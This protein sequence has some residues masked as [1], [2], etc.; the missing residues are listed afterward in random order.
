MTFNGEPGA[1]GRRHGPR[2]N[3]V[4]DAH[5]QL[6]DPHAERR[7]T[8]LRRLPGAARIAG[9]LRPF[10]ATA[11]NAF[12]YPGTKL[13]SGDR[14]YLLADYAADANPLP[15]GAIV[16]I[17]SAW[18]DSV[19]GPAGRAHAVLREL[20]GA[21]LLSPVAETRWAQANAIG[22]APRIGAIVARADVTS[23]GLGAV[24]DAHCAASPLV[25]GVTVEAAHHPDPGVPSFTAHHRPLALP[26]FL[27][28][29][30]QIAKRG[31]S[32]DIWVYSHDLPDVAALARR[33]PDV[34]IVLDHFATPA[35]VLG[36]A[37]RSTG[38]SEVERRGLLTAWRED[39]AVVARCPNVTVKI[40]GIA[41]P[42]LGHETPLPGR[43]VSAGE[44]ASRTGHLVTAVL[45]IFG[46]DRTMWGSY[47]PTGRSVS[48][49]RDIADAV[50]LIVAEW[51]P[52]A[53]D[54]VFAGTA[55][56]VYGIGV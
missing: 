17:A 24:L 16:Q 15:V 3:D 52:G 41:L 10:A 47:I 5:V 6:W 30:A 8:L 45:E 7:P 51:D 19:S 22:A 21:H 33:Y 44:L 53:L 18:H 46:P 9:A 40:S 27:D 29:F 49:I 50:A 48:R 56:R 20:G 11:A 38:L 26:S 23:P 31:L 34:S 39:L 13:R 32:C 1:S 37:G 42:M 14:A 2:L 36:H 12:P 54:P 4:V 55:T 25:R 43:S 28:G 35:G